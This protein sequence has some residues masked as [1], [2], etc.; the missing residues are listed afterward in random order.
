MGSD[1]AP[2][3]LIAGSR[4]LP[5][6]FAREARRQGR[7]VVATAFDGE[8]DPALAAEVDDIEWLRVGQLGKMIRALAD[9]GV[10]ECVMLGQ[11]A[12]KNLFD[13]RPDLRAMAILL[14]LKRRNAH[15]LFGAIAEELE[16]DGIRLVEALPWVQPWVPA[17]GFHAGPKTSG[18]EREDLAYGLGIALE[19]ARLDIGQSVVVKRGTTLAVEGFEGTDA[20]IER[21]GKLA[22]KDGG[23]VVVKVAKAGHD[24][25]FDIPCIG[26]RTVEACAAAGVRVLAVEA[27]RSLL[28]ERA[29]VESL[30]RERGISVVAYARGDAVTSS[31]S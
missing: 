3:G 7:R 1:L 22:G 28:L 19:I 25:R 6:V 16:K 12:P 24:M 2:L 18:D 10:R 11:I 27:G 15:T 29:E 20:C 26:S 13:L 14:R 23:A 9:R 21:G 17:T 5:F 30:A 4:L 31:G 8:T